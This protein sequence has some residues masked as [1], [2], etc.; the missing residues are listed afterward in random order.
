MIGYGV[1]WR[2]QARD[3]PCRKSMQ[4]IG[5]EG[6]NGWRDKRTAT[7]G[8][9]CGCKSGGFLGGIR[10]GRVARLLDYRV[11]S[12]GWQVAARISDL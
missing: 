1:G 11:A 2:C 6:E 4:Q 12:G 9:L 7:C 5:S 10:I 3:L 8:A